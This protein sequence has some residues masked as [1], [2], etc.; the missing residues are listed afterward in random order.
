MDAQAEKTLTLDDLF[1]ERENP[2][3]WAELVLKIRHHNAG[4]EQIIREAHVDAFKKYFGN[5]TFLAELYNGGE[6]KKVYKNLDRLGIIIP[7]RVAPSKEQI[8]TQIELVGEGCEDGVLKIY[9][10]NSEMN[11]FVKSA[12]E[13]F[14]KEG[15]G[16]VS[17]VSRRLGVDRKNLIRDHLEKLEVDVSAAR[18]KYSEDYK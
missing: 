3:S 2:M 17:E 13:I 18:R 1:K 14:I 9:Y 10:R 11:A 16:N 12:Y 6:K 7:K 15:K 4:V 5:I 8:I